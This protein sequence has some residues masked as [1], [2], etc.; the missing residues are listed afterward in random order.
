LSG[1][2]TG[3]HQMADTTANYDDTVGQ[4]LSQGVPGP[5]AVGGS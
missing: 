2:A 3:L 5:R 4:T 1:I